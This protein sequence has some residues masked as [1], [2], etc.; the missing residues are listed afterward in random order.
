MGGNEALEKLLAIDPKTRVIV[1]SGYLNNPVMTEYRKYGFSCVV[2]K[3]YRIHN[4]GTTLHAIIRD[5]AS[6]APREH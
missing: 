6:G 4:L 2:T 1:S 3:P 5:K